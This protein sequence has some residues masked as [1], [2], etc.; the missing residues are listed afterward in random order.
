MRP[1]AASGK[2]PRSSNSDFAAV[3]RLASLNA[4]AKLAHVLSHRVYGLTISLKSRLLTLSHIVKGVVRA[5][6]LKRY[7]KRATLPDETHLKIQD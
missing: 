3:R 1:Y 7:R 5:V 2:G 6:L 4:V